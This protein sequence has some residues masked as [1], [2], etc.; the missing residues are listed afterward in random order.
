MLNIKIKFPNYCSFFPVGEVVG[1]KY[2][3]LFICVPARPG[4][5][6]S[7]FFSGIGWGNIVRKNDAIL[8]VDHI[9]S[10]GM[11]GQK[12]AISYRAF[13]NRA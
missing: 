5:K 2:K 3:G 11:I 13:P 1:T 10:E 4:G 9:L 6:V 8:E 7:A 12:A